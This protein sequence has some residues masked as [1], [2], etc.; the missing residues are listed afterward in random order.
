MPAHC[1]FGHKNNLDQLM[2]VRFIRDLWA[3]L[4]HFTWV[5]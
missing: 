5:F 4:E 3:S 1:G 2:L